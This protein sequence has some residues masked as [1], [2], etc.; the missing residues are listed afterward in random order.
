MYTY[1]YT[2]TALK[3]KNLFSPDKYKDII[4]SSLQF[5]SDEEES[6]LKVLGFVIMP[7]HIHLLL[8]VEKPED[9]K[10][11]QLRFMKFTAQ[12]IKFD[13]RDNH[14]DILSLFKSTNGD[15]KY[16]FWQRNAKVIE[17]KGYPEIIRV[18]DYIHNNP[19][20]KKWSLAPSP[21]AYKYS[22]AKFYE[23]GKKDFPF[24]NHIS[25]LEE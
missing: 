11:F 6:T 10:R 18:L 3:W 22:S 25:V 12:Q 21:E 7:N 5:L 24:L 23:T 13:L 16:Q 15:R 9:L 17:L 14:P 20:S 8:A 4:T 1:F 2:A 19:L